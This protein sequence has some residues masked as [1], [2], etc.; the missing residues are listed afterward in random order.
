MNNH[1]RRYFLKLSAAGLA[2]G[3]PTLGFG[4]SFPSRTMEV[5][6]PT[7]AGGGADRNWFRRQFSI[8]NHGGVYPHS[9]RWR[10][11]S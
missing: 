5:Y 10:R 8:T 4:A 3:L 7:R 6:I 11:G 9:C 1:D 2:M